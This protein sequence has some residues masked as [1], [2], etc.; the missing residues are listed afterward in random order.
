VSAYASLNSQQIVSASINIPY[1][2]TWAGDVIVAGTATVPSS[3][4][5]C[6]IV[7]G[8][9]TLVGTAYRMSSFAGSRTVRLVGGYAGWRQVVASKAYANSAGV[10][11]S[12]VLRDAAG[13]VGEQL[14]LAQ[15]TTIGP[16]Y[17]RENA[18]A[19]RVLR[20]LA[21]PTWWMAMTGVTQVGPRT[22]TNVST[23]FTVVDWNGGK[24]VFDI[25]TEDNQS[26]M[27]GNTFM[28][29]TVNEVQT[30][31]MTTLLSDNKGTLRMRV[32]STG[33]SDLP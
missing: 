3:Q 30:I 10:K 17:I 8:N 7:F 18:P 26:W 13:E 22:T 5:G 9:L 6:T 32:L 1:Y 19:Q 23:P 24:G 14:T 12:M 20:Q 25:A 11:L 2:G 4:G 33:A 29:D 21:G 16:F 31:G 28:T 27:P 15:D